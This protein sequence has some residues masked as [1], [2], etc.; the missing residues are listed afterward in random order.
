[1]TTRFAIVENGIV[2][3]VADADAEFAESQGWIACGEA[4]PGWLLVDGVFTK[5]PPDL[6][7]LARVIRSE[8]DGLLVES[9]W[10]VT[11]AIETGAP[12]SAEW[13]AY[14][15]ALRDLT[16]QA[17]FPEAVVWPTKPQ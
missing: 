15:Q 7:A 14:R 3:N 4:G 16:L 1:M 5:P 9:D 8:R 17:G 11:K 13:T 6:D 10:R 12:M 2:K